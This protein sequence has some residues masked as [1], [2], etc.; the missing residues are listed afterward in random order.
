MR[1]F[2]SRAEADEICDSLMERY[3]REKGSP[4]WIS[5]DL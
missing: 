2:L 3:H 1:N 4:V 5:M